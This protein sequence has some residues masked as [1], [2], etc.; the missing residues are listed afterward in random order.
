MKWGMF[1]STSNT[2][3]LPVNT[4]IGSRRNEKYL[5]SKS[6]TQSHLNQDEMKNFWSHKHHSRR[7]LYTVLEKNILLM[8]K[9]FD[10]C[11]TSLYSYVISYF[12]N[13]ISMKKEIRRYSHNK[14]KI[15]YAN[16]HIEY[17][18]PSV[19]EIDMI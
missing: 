7:A 1:W 5:P 16:F 10:R 2:L 14:T 6:H 17:I 12:L 8:T 19:V 4:S 3:F 11:C 15:T 9:D 18:I 13:C